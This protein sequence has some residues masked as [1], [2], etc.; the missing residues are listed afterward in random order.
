LNGPAASVRFV[1]DLHT[2]AIVKQAIIRGV[3]SLERYFGL[4]RYYKD[5]FIWQAIVRGRLFLQ[6]AFFLLRQAD[7]KIR[8]I[9][10]CPNGRFLS[11]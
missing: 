7:R 3:K 9:C 11:V 8:N 4:I 6:Q 1:P 10:A 2:E 5:F